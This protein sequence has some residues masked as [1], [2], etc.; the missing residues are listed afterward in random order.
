MDVH[1]PAD[2]HVLVLGAG[3]GLL[4]LM[5]A[6]AGARRVTA[7]ERSRML[8]RMARQVLEANGD[9]PNAERVHLIDRKLRAV[10]IAGAQFSCVPLE[11]TA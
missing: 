3:G 9:A 2:A 6:A 10:G 1:V 8:Y 4:A 5:A 11:K 7:V